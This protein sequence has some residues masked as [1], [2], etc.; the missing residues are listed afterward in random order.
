[1]LYDPAVQVYHHAARR[2]FDPFPPDSRKRYYTVSHNNT[3][4]LLKN[5]PGLRKLGFLM[6]TFLLGDR[7]QGVWSATYTWL[8]VCASAWYGQMVSCRPFEERLTVCLRIS[9]PILRRAHRVV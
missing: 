4:V 9:V 5:L 2:E 6:Y 3:Y 1:M 8:C 7:Y